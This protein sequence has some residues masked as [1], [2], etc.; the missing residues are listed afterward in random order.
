MKHAHKQI[1]LKTKLM[2]GLTVVT[3]ILVIGTTFCRLKPMSVTDSASRDEQCWNMPVSISDGRT[4]NRWLMR[5]FAEI[6]EQHAEVISRFS[7][8][9]V[10]SPAARQELCTTLEK[11]PFP[12]PVEHAGAPGTKG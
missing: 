6:D 11:L 9:P 4:E 7:S 2:I 3:M 8:L 5:Q 10:L 1:P 12:A